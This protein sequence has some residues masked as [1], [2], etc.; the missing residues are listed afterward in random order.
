LVTTFNALGAEVDLKIYDTN[1]ITLNSIRPREYEAIL[2][3]NVINRDIDYYAFWHSS[4]RNDPGLNL[5][6]YTSIESDKSLENARNSI[7]TEE[8]LS[9]LQKF[10]KEVINDVPAIFLYSPDF[11]YISPR[12]LK[13]EVPKNIVTSSD[14][15]ADVE[16]WFIETDSVWKIFAN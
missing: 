4:Q 9:L 12:N 3:G 8:K 13:L 14:R 16:K 15:F 11:I 7:D 5:A 6:S 10:E 1:D 2:F